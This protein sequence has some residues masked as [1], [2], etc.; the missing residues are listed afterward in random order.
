M[1]IILSYIVLH[2]SSFSEFLFSSSNTLKIPHFLLEKTQSPG[3]FN[4]LVVVM[5]FSIAQPQK[6][7]WETTDATISR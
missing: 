4:L 6:K 2:F 3:L 1:N 7:N 5:L